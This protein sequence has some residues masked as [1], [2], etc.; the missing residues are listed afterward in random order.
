MGE[1]N[2]GSRGTEREGETVEA[3]R[4][5][6]EPGPLAKNYMEK[7]KGKIAEEKDGET[8][9]EDERTGGGRSKLEDV[10]KGMGG[11]GRTGEQ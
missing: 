8:S 10:L 4:R 9:R 2:D 6:R 5:Q 7:G 3:G 11:R 1:G